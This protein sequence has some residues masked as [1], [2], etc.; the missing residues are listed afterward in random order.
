M[1]KEKWQLVQGCPSDVRHKE[2]FLQ[3]AIE[4]NNIWNRGKEEIREYFKNSS[5]ASWLEAREVRKGTVADTRWERTKIPLIK[6]FDHGCSQQ[7]S[8]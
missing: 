8:H 3:Q 5:K 2:S 6:P 1:L 7:N 4:R